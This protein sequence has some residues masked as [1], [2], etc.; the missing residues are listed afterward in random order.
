VLE[1]SAAAATPGSVVYAGGTELLNWLRI[2]I[3]EP[4]RLVDLRLAGP[5]L[6][7]IRTEGEEVRIG[8]LCALNE[9]AAHPAVASRFPVLREAIHLSASAQL[10]NL[11]TVGG[12]PLQ[13]TRCPYFRAE[14]P[15]PC[16]KRVPGSGCAARHG[17]N[18]LHALFGWTDD[19]VAVQPS[20]PAAALAALDAELEITSAG[21]VRRLPV[22]ELHVLPDE[23]PAKHHRL[24]PGDIITAVVLHGEAPASAYVK[25][26]ER[27]SYEY[28]IV[29]AAAVVSVRD[30]FLTDVRIALGSV[31]LKPWRLPR[32]ERLLEGAPATAESVRAAVTAAMADARPLPHN[33]HKVP[34]GIG[35]ACRAVENA[36]DRGGRA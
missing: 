32:A 11:A 22:G 3:D 35:A 8:A 13:A 27:Q 1:A 25:V 19:C 16:N 5:E 33:G 6:R 9:V 36:I 26:R 10:R 30:G 15:T 17:A 21:G 7:G 18:E 12:N 29:S 28:A 31:A 34:I 2:G 4:S 20:D 23:D 14:A 24:A